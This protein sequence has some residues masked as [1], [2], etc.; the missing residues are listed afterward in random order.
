VASTYLSSRGIFVS[1]KRYAQDL[2]I[3]GLDHEP[4]APGK[5]VRKRKK[6]RDAQGDEITDFK[7]YWTYA[8]RKTGDRPVFG[9]WRLRLAHYQPR[10]EIKL[11]PA[12]GG[13]CSAD[14]DL[15]FETWGA[16]VIGILP[17][18]PDGAITAT[19]SW[20]ASI[21]TEYPQH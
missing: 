19:G 9:I 20:S 5:D 14:F 21:W 7:V 8:D 1:E 17:W 3:L 15:Y 6:W 18:I 13:G 11:S 12:E 10:G 16:N 4:L 2:S